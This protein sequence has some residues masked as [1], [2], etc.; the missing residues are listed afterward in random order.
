MK[1]IPIITSRIVT[2]LVAAV[3]SCALS[4]DPLVLPN[5]AELFNPDGT[6]KDD[7]DASGQPGANGVA[8]YI[9]FYGGTEVV[10]LRDNISNGNAMDMTVL[11]SGVDVVDNGTISLPEDLG[12]TY[13]FQTSDYTGN[14]VF[15]LAIERLV[16]GDPGP[17]LVE[18]KLHQS[19]NRVT[20]GAPWPI[21]GDKTPGDVLILINVNDGVV[22]SVDVRKWETD[23]YQTV[24]S[25]GLADGAGCSDDGQG[26]IA[27]LV[28]TRVQQQGVAAANADLWDGSGNPV[29][30]PDPDHL[31]EVG[32]NP[33]ALAGTPT[34]PFV[35]IFV[36]T[37]T[38]IV[39]GSLGNNGGGQ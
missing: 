11:G 29:T 1:H 2:G 32:I 9:D 10:L 36:R 15:Y 26:A 6:I 28:C 20:M 17:N 34:G 7:V 4:A 30:V 18:I 14:A 5:W 12:H 3:L 24:A 27:F 23:A 8:D 38:D 13:L 25:A 39:L 21:Q 16:Q 35:S 19:V 37:A 31:I 33:S 22:A